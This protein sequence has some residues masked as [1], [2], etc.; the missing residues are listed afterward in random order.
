VHMSPSMAL[1]CVAH[2]SPLFF[3]RT[4]PSFG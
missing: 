3:H 2:S 4:A 1:L